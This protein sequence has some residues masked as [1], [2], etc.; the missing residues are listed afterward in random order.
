MSKGKL[1]V[2]IVI[3]GAI[4]AFFALDLG[5]YLTLEF[6]KSKQAD[7]QAYYAAHQ[8]E[9]ILIYF[10]GYVIMAALSLPGAALTTLVGGALFGLVVGV[11]VVSFAS[12]IGAT[13]AF[14][15]SRF[16]L[17]DAIQA[18]YGDRLKAINEGI[19]KDGAFYLF[20][21]RMIP[22]I[23][24]FVVN[25]VMGITSIKARTFY[26]VSQVGMFLGTIVFVNAGA[27]SARGPGAVA[28]RA[29]G[30]RAAVARASSAAIGRARPR[31]VRPTRTG[32][33][34]I[35]RAVL[36]SPPASA[37]GIASTGR[38]AC[39]A[40]PASASSICSSVRATWPAVRVSWSPSVPRRQPLPAD[41]R[42]GSYSTSPVALRAVSAA[43]R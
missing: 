35:Y 17:R 12:S 4:G 1:L 39:R 40:V 22:A 16:L 33:A 5:Q 7:L 32:N 38:A 20:T 23:P 21:I 3:A 28:V 15:V 2:L 29:S 31:A 6:F 19:A 9:T 13:L 11:I 36:P 26:W 8:V 41:A 34:G 25:L 24:F 37:R 42:A 27:S 43:P 10:V 14:L 30:S 18:K